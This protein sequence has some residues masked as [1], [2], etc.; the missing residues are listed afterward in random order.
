MDNNE[1]KARVKI[2]PDSGGAKQA[3]DD[4][5]NI[6]DETEKTGDKAKQ[7]SFSFRDFASAAG[8]GATAV[9]GMAAAGIGFGAKIAGDLESA[10]QG[11]VA[12]L[13]SAEK[14]DAT[15][16][17]IKREAAATP[18]EI[19][20]LVKGTQ[21]LAAI[22]KDGD[23]AIDMLMDVG[24]AVSTSGKGQAELD[25]VVLNLQ[26]ISSTGKV[27]A[28]DIKQFQSAIPIFNDIVKGAGM[29]V[30]QLQN[31]DNAGELLALAFKHAGEEGG[32]AAKGFT[33]QAGTFNQ[34][35]SN[36]G[37][38]LTIFASDFVTQS[39]IFNVV[40][41]AIGGFTTFVSTASPIIIQFTKD[42]LGNE[43]GLAILGGIIGG[44]LVAAGIAF[45]IT[46]GPIILATLAFAA[47]GAA[48]G[49]VLSLLWPVIQTVTQFLMEHQTWLVAI[50]T[51]I[52]VMLVPTIW[53]LIT[54]VVT[55][56]VT[57]ITTAIPAII[58]TII[59]MGP[60]ILTALLVAAVIALVYKA[61]TNNWGNI[62]GVTESII[63]FII[64]KINSLIDKMNALI[65]I[66]N[67]VVSKLGAANLKIGEIGKLGAIS[68][69]KTVNVSSSSGG[70][71]ALPDFSSFSGDSGSFI[72]PQQ[73]SNGSSATVVNNNTN[74]INQN[75]NNYSQ[76]DMNSV[77]KDT[78]WL[79]N[80]K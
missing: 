18:F 76:M 70:S 71:S 56:A 60:L 13:G 3:Q 49:F 62:R 53:G 79:L 14:A 43:Q 12:I 50:G 75:N 15:M 17:R 24:K 42:V 73:S 74:V 34:L 2:D 64:G 55:M 57:F 39:G 4:I 58:A 41:D 54:S 30:D 19:P 40:K 10:R 8:L 36:M 16:A 33:S 47:A 9:L 68:I 44:L 51:F 21:A 22:T 78:S 61:W 26:Q 37:D 48:L 32:I 45:L 27:T 69:D 77:L 6:G 20:G 63:N 67:A 35:V 5:K 52:A 80:T 46:F 66:Y 23:K 11:F 28:M 38:S 25:R 72:G 65:G 31:A 7:A 59:A 29:T 1:I